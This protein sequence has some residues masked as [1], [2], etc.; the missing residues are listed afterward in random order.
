MNCPACGDVLFF[1]GQEH[2]CNDVIFV[3]FKS[4]KPPLG[5]MPRKIHL[6]KR[7]GELGYAIMNYVEAR[8]EVPPEWVDEYNET[9]IL[10][11]EV[12]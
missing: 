7:L 6:E 4:T 10:L 9:L 1:N 8:L 3:E 5:V 12:E 2:V 11:Q